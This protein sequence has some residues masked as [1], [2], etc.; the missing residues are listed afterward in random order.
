MRDDGCHIMTCPGCKSVRFRFLRFDF[1]PGLTFAL[2]PPLYSLHATTAAPTP[3]AAT[4]AHRGAACSAR[5]ARASAMP[6]TNKLY[7]HS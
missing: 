1:E 4:F 6:L 7:R 5:R 2:L 3:K